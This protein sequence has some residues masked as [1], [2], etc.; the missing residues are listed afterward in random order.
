MHERL[1]F[2]EADLAGRALE[3][4]EIA[5][6]GDIDQAFVHPAAAFEVDEDRRRDFIPVPGFIGS[7][8]MI[9]LDLA[10]GRVDGDR[11]CRIEVVARALVADPRAAVSGSDEKQ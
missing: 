3:E 6:A 1:A 4:P 9:A 11:R 10:G 8:L 5:I 7:V 2:N